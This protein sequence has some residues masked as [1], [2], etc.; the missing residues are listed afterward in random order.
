MNIEFN[1]GEILTNFGLLVG[2]FIFNKFD[3]LV[4]YKTTFTE[5]NKN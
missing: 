1:F 2:V 4:L 5:A 3:L